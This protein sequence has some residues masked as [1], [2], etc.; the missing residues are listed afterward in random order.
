MTRP[1]ISVLRGMGRTVGWPSGAT[2]PASR[3]IIHATA[4]ATKGAKAT[5]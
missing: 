1:V 2:A 5:V 4:R 3:P